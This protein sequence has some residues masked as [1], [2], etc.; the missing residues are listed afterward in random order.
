MTANLLISLIKCGCLRIARIK[1]ETK[2]YFIISALL[3]SEF[4]KL[5]KRANPFSAAI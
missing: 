4:K 1:V 5:F 2:Y 3:G